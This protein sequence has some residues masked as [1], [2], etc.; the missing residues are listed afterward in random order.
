ML[1]F[2]AIQHIRWKIIGGGVTAGSIAFLIGQYFAP[3]IK[4]NQKYKTKA[5]LA[6]F[7]VTI[8]GK[9]L[10]KSAPH[11]LDVIFYM[12]LG[13]SGVFVW[14]VIIEELNSSKIV[15][16]L[17]KVGMMSLELYLTNI[18]FNSLCGQ[19]GSPLYWIGMKDSNNV[20]RYLFVL[21][22][23]ILTSVLITKYRLEK[24]ES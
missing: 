9:F 19:I 7:I 17:K 16:L 13:V 24:G 2:L 15:N 11:K 1:N 12:L 14:P 23:G 3:K 20:G 5:L 4:K 10:W 21:F 8:F 18:Y 22:F 6:L